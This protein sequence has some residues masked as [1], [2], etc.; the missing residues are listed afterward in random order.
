M[1]CD[2]PSPGLTG[3]ALR[4]A[5]LRQRA[6]DR[7]R[8][9]PPLAR[10]VVQ[11]RAEALG[12]TRLELSRRSGIGRSTL[13]DLE[14]GLHT[15]TRR[16]LQQLLCFCQ[17]Q[18]APPEQ[19]EQLR[20]LYAGAG[21]TLEQFL[22]RLELLAGS[23][24]EL[25]RRVG[26]SA[27]TLW[28]YRRGNFPLPFDL[29]RQ[30]CAAVEEEVGPGEGLWLD[31]ERRRLRERGYPEALVEFWAQAARHGHAEKDLLAHG[32]PTTAARRL[33]YLD[34]PPW[35]DVAAVARRLCNTEVEYIR[36]QKLWLLDLQAQAEVPHDTFGSRIRRL[37]EEQGITRRELADLFGVG[38][39]KPARLLK[40]VEDDDFYSTLAYP[41]GLAAL[42]TTEGTERACL[43]KLWQQRRALFHRRHRPETRTD[44]RLARE[45]YGFTPKD[46]EPVLGYT[47]NEYLRLERGV[48]PLAET[49]RQRIL[50]AIHQAGQKRIER[51]LRQRCES[52]AERSAWQTPA[53]VP[54]LIAR[55]SQREGGL[56]PLSRYLRGAGLKGFWAG[57]LRA[58]VQEDEVPPWPI[59]EELA[60]TCG[61]K[62]L[63]DLRDD[64]EERY[65][66]Q[67]EKEG[68]SPLAVELR[69]V[70]AEQATTLRAF[71]PRLGFNYSVLVRDFQRIDRDTPI[72]WTHVARILRAAGVCEQSE[73]WRQ[74][75]ALWY[76]AA[77]R[78]RRGAAST[79]G[80]H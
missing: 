16:V 13:R 73:R 76:T 23:A 59:L 25:A 43:L 52:L 68:I 53:T 67:L 21:E 20:R 77:E 71:S 56:I 36:L 54:E 37:R 5:H 49:A 78:C 24:R 62:T 51:L 39:K 69:L 4:N 19:L 63:G 1:P 38:G 15:P 79:N 18:G 17:Q 60:G 34:L 22:A 14:L 50:T 47:A 46:L 26:I 6:L 31:A 27:A 42:L 7:A 30:L 58:I 44:L 29:L 40:H 32:L 65:R 2:A 35:K 74:A 61:L 64:W 66:A 10:A 70:I 9:A 12:L 3:H 72:R 80:R 33:R 57:R 28:E 8:T 45:Q 41:A 75:H 55:L 48:G 11:L